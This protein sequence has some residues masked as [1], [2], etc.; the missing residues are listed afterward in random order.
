MKIAHEEI[1]LDASVAEHRDDVLRAHEEI[2]QAIEAVKHPAGTAKFTIHPESG[3]K[4]GKGNGVVLIRKAFLSALCA[5]DGWQPE[6]R[7]DLAAARQP[8]SVDAVRETECGKYCVEWETGNISSCHRSL[9]KMALALFKGTIAA[10]CVI[11]PSQVLRPFLTDRIANYTE[12]EPYLDLWKA[13]PIKQGRLSILVVEHDEESFD[14]P[15]IP[16]GTDGRSLL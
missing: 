1:L 13:V 15:R 2:K 4:H 12:L 7:L 8:G 11:V 16:K 10:G 9:N 5:T 3:K 14:V 6:V